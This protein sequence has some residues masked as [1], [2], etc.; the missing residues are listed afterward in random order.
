MRS[1]RGK[2]VTVDAPGSASTSSA[3]KTGA[4]RARSLRDRLGP[5]V[6]PQGCLPG[7]QS[8]G[9]LD[10]RRRRSTLSRTI[11]LGAARRQQ[12]R[13]G[14]EARE[15]V[16]N[17][18][19]VSAENAVHAGCAPRASPSRRRPSERADL[20]RTRRPMG[21]LTRPRQRD[22]PLTAAAAI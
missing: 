17:S 16:R 21:P 20:V 9:M 1:R 3:G 12:L 19:A 18:C 6:P 13:G 11:A 7:V 14:D 5:A 8:R 15:G 4:R 2:S 22:L 10:R